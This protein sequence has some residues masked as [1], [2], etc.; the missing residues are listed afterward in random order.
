MRAYVPDNIS[1]LIF[2]LTFKPKSVQRYY[3]KYWCIYWVHKNYSD[4]N[5]S[6]NII[7]MFIFCKINQ[8]I[9][10]ISDCNNQT[11]QFTLFN[12]VLVC[13]FSLYIYL[14]SIE[15]F[16]V[17]EKFEKYFIEKCKCI[18]YCLSIWMNMENYNQTV[19]QVVNYSL[20]I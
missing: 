1:H 15:K 8:L 6:L 11:F 17:W 2:F 4:W 3:Y 10:Q 5:K 20:K 18:H 9:L 12:E 14:L 13:P 19:D 7:S 16:K